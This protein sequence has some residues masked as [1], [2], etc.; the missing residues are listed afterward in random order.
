MATIKTDTLFQLWKAWELREGRDLTL[1]EIC[2]STGLSGET[3]R[4]ILKSTTKRLDID[5]LGALCKFFGVAPG[6]VPFVVYEPNTTK[7]KK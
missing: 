4:G 7:T 6:P 3:V 1:T 5:T 2:E